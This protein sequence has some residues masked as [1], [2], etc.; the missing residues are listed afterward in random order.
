MKYIEKF[1]PKYGM[2]IQIDSNGGVL[3]SLHGRYL[4][5]HTYL[6]SYLCIAIYFFIVRGCISV[7]IYKRERTRVYLRSIFVKIWQEV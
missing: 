3:Q 4:Y 2:F 7:C 1:L 6:Y 5:I